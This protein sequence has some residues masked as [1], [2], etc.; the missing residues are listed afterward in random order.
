MAS[1]QRVLV[2]TSEAAKVAGVTVRT[3]QSWAYSG[4]IVPVVQGGNG[5]RQNMYR[6]SDILAAERDMRKRR[7]GAARIPK[8]DWDVSLSS[9]QAAGR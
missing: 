7:H 2:S 4:L 5:A 8:P 6:L 1:S 3:I 9:R